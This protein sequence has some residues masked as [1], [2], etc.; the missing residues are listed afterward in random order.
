MNHLHVVGYLALLLCTSSAGAQN[1]PASIRVPVTFY[2]FHSNLSN[3][4]FEVIPSSSGGGIWKG[5]VRSTLDSAN[6]PVVGASPFFNLGI[7]QWFRP[8]TPGDSTIPNYGTGTP[9]YSIANAAG[10]S[11]SFIKVN[12]DTAYK[13]IVFQDTLV[14]TTYMTSAGTYQ[15]D[16]QNFFLLD[17]KGF[18]AEGKNHNFSFTMELHWRFVM[19]PG[20]HFQFTG[21]DDVWGF[22]DNKQVID[23]GGRHNPLSG[24]VN[25]DTLGLVD[26][27]EYS[28]D[29]F[30]CERHTNSATIRIISNIFKPRSD[31]LSLAKSPAIDTVA[32]GDSII[33]TANVRDINGT[34][35]TLCSQNVK[36]SLAPSTDSTRINPAPGRQTTLYAVSAYKSYMVTAV[37][38]NPAGTVHLIVA[39]TIYVKP[40]V[41]DHLTIE[42]NADSLVSLRNDAP[43]RPNAIVF[44]PEMLNDSVYAILR[45]RFGNWAGH[46]TLATW[47]SGDTTVIT[48]A[49]ARTQLG[50][51]KLTRQSANR[52]T[53]VI[54]AAQGNLND[55]LRVVISNVTYSRIQVHVDTD[56]AKAI[57]TLRIRAGQDTTLHARGFRAD[58]SGI[59]DDLMVSWGTSEGLMVE[60]PVP[61]SGNAWKISP[62]EPTTGF[63][64]ISFYSESRLLCD[65]LWI[66]VAPSVKRNFTAWANDNMT[67]LS[68]IDNDD[69]VLL[70]FDKP[71]EVFPV[72]AATIDSVF[73]LS[74][75]HSWLSG[76]G[77]IG[78]AQWSSD[79]TKLLITLSTED[80]PPTIQIGD[81][82]TCPSV[83]N[84]IVLTGS[85]GP[86]VMSS[87]LVPPSSPARLISV[88]QSHRTGDLIFIFSSNAIHEMKIRILDI[89]GRLIADCGLQNSHGDKRNHFEWKINGQGLKNRIANGT[90]FALVYRKEVLTQSILFVKK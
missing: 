18:G 74:N 37:Y 54:V 81:T 86:S 47:L 80:A 52:D 89:F 48:V 53:V 50:E 9:E 73:P 19:E 67:K 31:S 34:L 33:F 61:I 66:L 45:D 22:I 87:M 46:A 49:S 75:G 25:V 44:S 2:D 15:Y 28:F 90:Y 36:W 23:V 20:L 8:W 35:C 21:D 4:E 76:A 51:G 24:A 62:K 82:I 56:A 12:Y 64:F 26:G 59:W 85:F 7:A 43:I 79:K 60:D 3:P 63:V 17:G 77:S 32:A 40:G 68:G 88:S 10:L 14:F 41:P 11:P 70:T 29:F 65:T 16:N 6:K 58:G 13:N 84:K 78:S 1:Y 42:A 5:M 38:D 83:E 39:D 71:V 27:K 55:S 72:S 30:Y 69:Y 57:D